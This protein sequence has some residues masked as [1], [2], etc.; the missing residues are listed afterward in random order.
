MVRELADYPVPLLNWDMADPTNPSM[1]QMALAAADK[2]LVGG[3]DRVLFPDAGA[4][5]ALLAQVEAARAAMKNRPFVLGSTCT[6][7]TTSDPDMVRALREAAER[8]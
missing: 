2:I 3:V 4:R 6:I 1:A 7:D 8:K 5:P